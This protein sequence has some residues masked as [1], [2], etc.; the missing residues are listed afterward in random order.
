MNNPRAHCK[1]YWSL[2]KTLVNGRKVSLIPP[3]QIGDKFIT[4]FTEKDRAFNDC[5]AKKNRVNDRNSQ[6]PKI[7]Q[8]GYFEN[9]KKS[10]HQ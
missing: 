7:F 3:I 1:I 10:L 2:L 8:C 6:P 4:N 9:P 5:F